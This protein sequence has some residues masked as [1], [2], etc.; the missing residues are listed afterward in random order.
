MIQDIQKLERQARQLE[1]SAKERNHLFAKAQKYGE[2]FLSSLPEKP[3]YVDDQSMGKGV[4]ELPFD[5]KPTEFSQLLKILKS[6]VDTPGLNPASGKHAGYIPG[7]GLYPSAIAD[8]LAAVTNRYTGVFF[9]SPGAVR[10]ENMCIRWMNDL[11]GYPKGA[12]GNLTSGGSIANL[13]AL[14]VARDQSG[15]KARDFDRAVIYTT[16]QVHHCVIKAIKFAGLREATIRTISMDDR[17]RMEPDA[18]ASQIKTDKKEGLIPLT[19]FASAGTTD[20]GAVDP[21]DNIG[22]IAKKYDLWFH[23]DAAYGGFFLLTEHG[24]KVMKGIEKSD[25]A[26]IDPH[27]GLFLPYGSGAL[28]VKDGQKLYESQHM[29]ANYLQDTYKATEEASP[30]DLSPELSKHFRGLR[31]WL[32][33]QLFGVA[34]FRATLDEKLLLTRYF[35]NEIQ[36]IDGIEVGPEPELSVAFFRYVPNSGDA[37]KFNK[38]LIDEIHSDGRVFLSSTHLN[39]TIYLRLAV[40]NFRTHLEEV[41]LILSVLREKIHELA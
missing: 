7:G 40:L 1:T 41:D 14:V 31:M 8:Y 36:Q 26:T 10:I 16:R 33:L 32:P 35:Y 39:G 27:K 38:K 9:S 22:D 12:S 30:A 13:I 25:S 20:L 24:K 37:N 3:A 28:L 18:L 19:V 6:E 21:L 17:Y 23:V 2:K 5:E 34:P 4:Y 11:I 15:I 29:S